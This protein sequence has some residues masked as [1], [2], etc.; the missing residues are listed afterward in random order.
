MPY[1]QERPFL[2]AVLAVSYPA[3]GLVE[4]FE[5]HER[6]G[7][8][9]QDQDGLKLFRHHEE[10]AIL[11]VRDTVLLDGLQNDIQARFTRWSGLRGF[12]WGRRRWFV[13]APDHPHAVTQGHPDFLSPEARHIAGE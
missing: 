7:F 4:D 5:H 13:H 1:G 3:N 9:L 2:P 10:V 12:G 11:G 6:H 8:M